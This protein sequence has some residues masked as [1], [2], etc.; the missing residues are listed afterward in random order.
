MIDVKHGKGAY[1][2]G[3]VS[4]RALG[5]VLIPMFADYD[6][7]RRGDLVEARNLLESEI[8]AKVAA[9]RTEDDL[10]FLEA[11]LVCDQQELSEPEVFAGKDIEFHLALAKRCGND[12][13]YAMYQALHHQIQAFLFHYARSISDRQEALERHRPILEAIKAKDVEKTRRLA[14]EHAAICASF[15]KDYKAVK[16]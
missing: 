6:P 16:K 10:V 12:F 1:V 7:V 14:R 8:A 5:N 9:S 3:R 4:A 13:F 15:I 11:L 2:N